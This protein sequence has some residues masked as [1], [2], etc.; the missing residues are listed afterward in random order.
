MTHT[1]NRWVES[2]ARTQVGVVHCTLYIHTVALRSVNNVVC[3]LQTRHAP[4]SLQTTNSKQHGL[5]RGL[6]TR[7]ALCLVYRQTDY[8]GPVARPAAP[9]FALPP[10]VNVYV[11]CGIQ[12]RAHIDAYTRVRRTPNALQRILCS[13]CH[14]S[15]RMWHL[16]CS[17]FTA[18]SS[19]HVAR[20]RVVIHHHAKARKLGANAWP[21]LS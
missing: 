19:T 13:M 20:S 18:S 2:A 9:L 6:W 15:S 16:T 14:H 11:A 17:T 12:G 4:T 8:S 5:S 7:I 21:C 1:I 10:P 3:K